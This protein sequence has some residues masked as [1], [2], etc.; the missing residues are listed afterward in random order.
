[1]PKQLA[2]AIAV[3]SLFFITQ[4]TVA[5]C[6][7]INEILINA[8]GGCDGNC[9]PSTSEAVELYNTCGTPI[10]LSCF[11]LTDG[12]FA[13]TFPAGTIIGAN[14]FLVIGST[15]SPVAPDIDL[16]SCNCTS[17]SA[18]GVFTNGNEQVY[19]VNSA[20]V[21]QDAIFWGSGQF[22]VNITTAQIGTCAPVNISA[23]TNAGAEQLPGG[24]ADGCTVSRSCDGSTT[25]IATCGAASTLGTSNGAP[26]SP[27]FIADQTALCPG[28]CINF[29]DLT[30]QLPLSWGWSFEG[31]A[32]PTSSSQNPSSICYPNAGSFDVTLQV[33]T[34]CGSFVYTQTDYITVGSLT[35]PTITVTQGDLSLC[36]GETVTLS[37]AAAGNIQWYLDG[38]I[39]PGATLPNFIATS[40]GSYTVEVGAGLCTAISTPVVVTSSPIP[41]VIIS[42]QGPLSFC[43]GNSVTLA[44]TAAFGSY[45]WYENGALMPGQTGQSITVSAAGTYYLVAG[46]NGCTGTSNTINTSVT[47]NPTPVVS[48][49]GPLVICTGSS[50]NLT[51]DANYTSIQWFN[52]STAI[53]GAN[54]TVFSASDAGSYT[55][56]VTQNGCTGTSNA[57]VVTLQSNL[58]PIIVPQGSTLLCEGES[59]V[60]T[61]SAGYD[62]YLWYWNG[63]VLTGENNNSL[64]ALLAGTYIV[65][66][67]QGACSGESAGTQVFINPYPSAEFQS[68][69]PIDVCQGESFVLNT[70]TG[71]DQY[72]WSRNGVV[73]VGQTSA[74]FNVTQSGIYTVTVTEA[75]CST[76]SQPIQVNVVAVPTLAITPNS[77]S[78]C[79]GQSATLNASSGFTSYAWTQDGNPIGGTTNSIT[80][81]AAGT[82]AVTGLIGPGCEASSN[83]ALI[84][85]VPDVTPVLTCDPSN[86]TICEGSTAVITSSVNNSTTS[87]YLNNTLIVGVTTNT[88]NATLPG[89]YH[90]ISSNNG[91]P[92]ESAPQVLT[93]LPAPVVSITPAGPITQCSEDPVVLSANGA[94]NIEWYLNNVL[95]AGSTSTTYSADESG[96]YTAVLTS[97]AGCQS[98]SNA[99]QLTFLPAVDVNIIASTLAPCIGETVVLSLDGSFP[100]VQWTGGSSANTLNVTTSGTYNVGVVSAQGCP[101]L[102]DIEINFLEVPSITAG[103]DL[104]SDCV[105]GVQLEAVVPFGVISWSPEETLSNPAIANPIANP[106]TTT[107]YTLV[108]TNGTCEASSSVI[109]FAECSTI[110]IPNVFTPNGDGLND[111]FRAIANGVD[112]FSL[113]IFNR[114][115]QLLFE[116]TD[117]EKGW[118]GRVNDYYAPDGTYVWVAKAFDVEGKNM[119]N[120][121]QSHGTLTLIR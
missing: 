3:L 86:W 116:T 107:E 113:Q 19:L 77:L 48:P 84:T 41:T 121:N 68:T 53:V 17:G 118:D 104:F 108:V 4:Q 65:E 51:L 112:E 102:D 89:T 90:A 110:F 73:V 67:T 111:Y 57:V 87:W 38:G 94:G 14:D 24:G 96:S 25:W 37:T 2:K 49:A 114:W 45:A 101:G 6:I 18:I 10:D 98:T 79:A 92:G 55:A 15:S 93:V 9:S 52:G 97:N 64:N 42:P 21:V 8:A 11:V 76:T 7:V 119:L 88:L 100:T 33:T 85:V 36:A 31:A 69:G 47:A 29:S 44:A 103:P 56:Q 35:P 13:V 105:L 82:Y 71:Y 23:A 99:V 117:P 46:N 50:V 32:T 39:I 20:G 12:D 109:V 59:V 91:C 66:V 43:Q 34:A 106:I 115:G 26:A 83:S 27:D 28:D 40:A 62:S 1:M 30:A 75:N 81:S 72:E 120:F 5:Q 70:P 80:V 16:A 63:N 22:P 78:L 58:V 60:L 54:A 74:T 61:T 95:L